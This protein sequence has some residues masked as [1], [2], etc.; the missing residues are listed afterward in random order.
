MVQRCSCSCLPYRAPRRPRLAY[1]AQGSAVKHATPVIANEVR[2]HAVARDC[3]SL[4]FESGRCVSVRQFGAAST[5]KLY[6][7]SGLAERNG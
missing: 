1:A 6:Q 7:C 5:F 2:L 4:P 3:L